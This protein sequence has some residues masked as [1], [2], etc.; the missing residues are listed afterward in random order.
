[1][2]KINLLPWRDELRAKRK[3]LFVTNCAIA[4][5]LGLLTVAGTWFYYDQKLQDQEQANQ[6]VQS[7]NLTLDTQLKSL[8]GIQEQRNAIVERMKLIQG[9]QGQRPVSV[10]LLDELVRIAPSTLY[11]T[12]VTRTADRFQIEGKAENPNVVAEFLRALEASPWYRNAFMTA[13]NAYDDSQPKPASSLVPRVEE[14]YGSFVVTVD[15]ENIALPPIDS[16]NDSTTTDTA[17]AT[18]ITPTAGAAQ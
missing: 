5:I 15:L 17:G 9:L 10:R 6:L 2:A 16:N 18:I 3:A 7:S 12:K 11:L 14:S 1:M 4:G 8:D 13:F